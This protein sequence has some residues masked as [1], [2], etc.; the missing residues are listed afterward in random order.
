[1]VNFIDSVPFIS[2]RMIGDVSQQ[3][4]QYGLA[5]L[6]LAPLQGYPYKV[7]S[8]EAAAQ[9]LPL[10]SY[11][12]WSVLSRLER[13]LPITLFAGV[14]GIIFRKSIQKH[15]RMWLGIYATIWVVVYVFYW[16]VL[17]GRG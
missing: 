6:V 14:L 9:G 3:M 5:A 8:V 12:L 2:S 7:Y 11:L 1:M 16:V 13:L 10:W 17:P 4:A 15:T